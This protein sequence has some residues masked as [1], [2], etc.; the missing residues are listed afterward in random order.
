MDTYKIECHCFIAVEK[1]GG[2]IFAFSNK[3]YCEFA[4]SDDESL[5]WTIDKLSQHEDEKITSPWQVCQDGLGNLYVGTSRGNIYRS[6]YGL[7][8]S[9]ANDVYFADDDPI[10]WIK[11]SDGSIFAASQSGKCIFSTDRG[12]T[13]E[14]LTIE[15]H[16]V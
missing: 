3:P 13:W 14:C 10:L 2:T 11:A 9:L 16:Q 1:V 4:Y 15:S 12:L 7:Y 8:W 5:H 6:P